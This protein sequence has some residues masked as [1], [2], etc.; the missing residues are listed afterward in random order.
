MQPPPALVLA[1]RVSQPDFDFRGWFRSMSRRTLHDLI[2]GACPC[3]RRAWADYA[4]SHKVSEAITEKKLD[5]TAFKAF[6]EE[7]VI[8]NRYDHDQG[9]PFYGVSLREHPCAGS[10]CP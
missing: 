10:C 4:C 1:D 7:A 9:K 8:V 6:L 2:K 5:I 3:L